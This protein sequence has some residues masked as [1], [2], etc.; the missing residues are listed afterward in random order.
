[1]LWWVSVVS[2]PQQHAQPAASTVAPKWKF[3][4][5]DRYFLLF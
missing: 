2:G 3:A 1:M 4:C 5:F